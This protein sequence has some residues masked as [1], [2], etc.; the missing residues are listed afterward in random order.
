MSSRSSAALVALA[1]SVVLSAQ[2]A[3][4]STPRSVDQLQHDIDAILGSPLL[5]HSL[6]GIVVKP[7]DRDDVWYAKNGNTLM[8]P[9]SS[10]KVLTLAAAAEKLGW[11]Y[12][13]ETKVFAIGPIEAGVLHGDLVVV[14]SGDPS[15]DDWDGDATRVFGDWAAQL[16]GA[17][18]STISGRVVGDDHAFD[19]ETIGFGWAWDDLPAGFAAG[20]GALQFNE[21]NV[22]LR[23]GP[24]DAVGDRAIV[25]ITPDF[26]GLTL[27]NLIVTGPP[28]TIGNVTRRRLPGSSRL[29]L[30][31]T[32]PLRGRPYSQTASVDNPTLYFVNALRAALIADGITITG[33]AT[34]IDDLPIPPSHDRLTPIAAYQSPPLSMLAT[35]MMKLS[36]N[37]FAEALFKTLG[38]GTAEAA[39]MAERDTLQSWGID[40]ATVILADGSGLSRYNYITAQTMVAVLTHAA[41]SERLRA[42]YQSTLPIAGRDG[43]LELRMKGTPAEGRAFVKTGSMNGVRTAAGYVQTADGQMLVFAIL[44]NNFANSSAVINAATDEIIVRL[45][46][47]RSR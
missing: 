19:D 38:G 14:G 3:V 7:V 39:R 5:E 32:L 8:M 24:G 29:E 47:Y 2:S 16:K 22:Q 9:A 40:P 45:A 15:L 36:Q 42:T 46:S 27:N 4:P 10:L 31:G 33:P 11:E 21:G 25:T 41:R 20:V 35:T 34:D 23:L 6:W 12:R 44:A 26:A 1:C 28:D 37:Q 43:T 17:G 30:R 13:Y 18:I